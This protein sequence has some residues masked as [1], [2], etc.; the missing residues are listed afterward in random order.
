MKKSLILLTVLLLA[1]TFAFAVDVT[2]EWT[3]TLNV[4]TTVGYDLNVESGGIDNSPTSEFRFAYVPKSTWS[5][6]GEGLYGYI[7]AKDVQWSIINDLWD[8][9]ARVPSDDYYSANADSVKNDKGTITAKIVWNSLYFLISSGTDDMRFNYADN[10]DGYS[11]INYYHLTTNLYPNAGTLGVGYA[12]DMFS[13]RLTVLS[14]G[15]YASYPATAF[16]E[17]TDPTAFFA[18][19]KAKDASVDARNATTADEWAFG[20]WLAANPM[21]MLGVEVKAILDMFNDYLGFGGKITL[22][23]IDLISLSIPADAYYNLTSG[24]TDPFQ[25]DLKPAL[26]VN[27]G[28][29]SLTAS[30]YYTT[31]KMAQTDS[32]M[33]V[34]LK[35]VEADADA[36]YLPIVG[37]SL[38]A[39]L[40][41]LVP[42]DPKKL[43]WTIDAKVNATFGAWMPYAQ[44]KMSPNTLNDAQMTKINA[45]ITFSGIANT[46]IKLDYLVTDLG[47][48]DPNITIKDA[49]LNDKGR[50][51]LN[52]KISY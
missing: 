46:V 29:D 2:P 40:N 33:D 6:G 14:D 35:F 26:T 1:G 50:I 23:P 24:A 13:A 42:L 41:N 51:T 17:K 12:S 44:F 32:E 49:A 22:K 10:A 19:G 5:K 37:A 11:D 28:D 36:G 25:I 8:T 20:L 52:T 3:L 30:M 38:E 31:H 21:A 15:D 47:D 16:T 39:A 4:S 9:K 34:S 7:E 43:E 18:A 48:K 27:L 45:G